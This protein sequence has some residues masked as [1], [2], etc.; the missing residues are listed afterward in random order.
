M[1]KNAYSITTHE[2][3]TIVLAEAAHGGAWLTVLGDNGRGVEVHLS[4]ADVEGIRDL[5]N[6]LSERDEPQKE[7]A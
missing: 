4:A 6:V 7:T 2:Y 5:F 1:E 3:E